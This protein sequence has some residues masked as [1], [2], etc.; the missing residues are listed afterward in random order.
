[1]T[2]ALLVSQFSVSATFWGTVLLESEEAPIE[3]EANWQFL[4]FLFQPGIVQL[5][6]VLMR[7]S[8]RNGL[9]ASGF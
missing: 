6:Y 3:C 8:S 1:M 9:N 4:L 2:Q 7:Y 5:G